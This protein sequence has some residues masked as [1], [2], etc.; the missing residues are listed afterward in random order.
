MRDIP[1]HSFYAAYVGERRMNIM[2]FLCL[3]G[4][5]LGLVIYAYLVY[6]ELE[7]EGESK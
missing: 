3:F 5:G 1:L 7:K 4:S 2:V 6:K